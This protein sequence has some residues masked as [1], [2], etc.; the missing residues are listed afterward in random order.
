[1]T[2]FI[3]PLQAADLAEAD[4]IFRLA[5]GIFMRLVCVKSWQQ[6]KDDRG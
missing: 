3:R 6:V 2:S 1:M 5:F 4:H